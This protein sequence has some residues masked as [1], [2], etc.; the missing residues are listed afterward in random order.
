MKRLFSG[1]VLILAM[2]AATPTLAQSNDSSKRLALSHRFIELMQA[3][4]MG[5][6]LGQMMVQMSPS[7]SED[8]TEAEADEFA[9]V[10]AEVTADMMPRLFDAMAPVY[11]E[12]FTLEELEGLVAFYESDIGQSLMRKSYESGPEI[13]AAVNAI[14]PELLVEMGDEMCDHYE[15]TPDQRREM[16]ASMNEAAAAYRR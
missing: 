3:E 13:M 8:M 9:A 11:A 7:V 16:K 6:M 4:Q 1:L 12:I 15:C 10:M 5:A 2:L 14:M